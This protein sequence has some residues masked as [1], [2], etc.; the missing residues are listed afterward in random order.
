MAESNRD[1]AEEP[2]RKHYEEVILKT[3]RPTSRVVSNEELVYRIKNLV[4]TVLIDMT[5]IYLAKIGTMC[6][7]LV[8]EAEQMKAADAINDKALRFL[9]FL[10]E[11]FLLTAQNEAYKSVTS[12]EEQERFKD[13]YQP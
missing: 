6:I 3:V 13:I 11:E 12:E 4:D 8:E 7:R 1:I 10:T 2:V 5:N 9:K